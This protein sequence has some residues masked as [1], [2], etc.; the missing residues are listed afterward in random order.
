MPATYKIHPA[1]RLKYVR[2]SSSIEL[3]ELLSLAG[4][5]FR[6][7]QYTPK[8]RFL[9]DLT[10]LV[11]SRARF[12][13]AMTLYSFYADR[14]AREHRPVRVAIVAP[15][16]FAYGMSKMFASLSGMGSLMRLEI[17]PSLQD[18]M[19]WLDLSAPL[20]AELQHHAPVT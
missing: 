2:V 14:V 10:D 7:P 19:D 9:V 4:A 15:G 5:Y 8:Q 12:R 3:D 18:A 20:Q 13:D 1:D 17:F 6:D 11:S 16:N